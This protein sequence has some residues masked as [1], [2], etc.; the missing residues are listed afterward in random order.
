M[1]VFFS[2]RRIPKRAYTKVRRIPKSAF[3]FFSATANRKRCLRK[4]AYGEQQRCLNFFF[5][6]G[7]QEK[8]YEKTKS[9]TANQNKG[10]SFFSACGE[11]CSAPNIACCAARCVI[12]Y[13]AYAILY[14]YIFKRYVVCEHI[15]LVHTSKYIPGMYEEFVLL[16]MRGILYR[17]Q[18]IS[19]VLQQYSQ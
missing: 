7:E 17:Q 11:K 8:G 6:C 2:L 14:W 10:A 9:P 5:D 4:K 1:I 19:H 15:I 3:Q 18:Q 16:E 13:A 12:Y